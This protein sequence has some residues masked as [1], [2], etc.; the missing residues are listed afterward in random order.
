MT[1][2]NDE[3]KNKKIGLPSK[4]KIIIHIVCALFFTIAT[5]IV[6]KET[7]G[8]YIILIPTMTILSFLDDC[9]IAWSVNKKYTIIKYISITLMVFLLAI[10]GSFIYQ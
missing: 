1:P 10:V 5:Y 8:V 4:S 3:E 6:S 9:N 7:W 2:N